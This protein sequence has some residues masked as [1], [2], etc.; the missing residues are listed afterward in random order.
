MMMT[1]HFPGSRLLALI[2]I[3]GAVGCAKNPDAQFAWRDSTNDLLP[4]A[5]RA[6]QKSMQENFGTP[7]ALVAWERMPVQYGGVKGTV[8]SAAQS[9]P[10]D[11]ADISAEWSAAEA[12]ED[13]APAVTPSLKVGDEVLWISG[14]GATGKSP[15]SKISKVVES[16]Q[17]VLATS[18]LPA[19]GD[20]FFVN[21]GH[22][23]QLGR[24]VYMKNCV[25]CH[26]VAGDGAGPTAHYLNPRPRDYRLGV[27]KFT[28]TLATER[29]THH[30]LWRVIKYGI[31]GTYMP[32]FLLLDDAET[33]AVVQYVRWLAMR[34]EMEKRLGD[35]LADYSQDGLREEYR[36]AKASYDAAI[37][38]GEKPDSVPNLNAM[39][40]KARQELQG[41]LKDDF[42]DTVDG[43]ADF[44]AE[45]WQRAEDPA[46]V[47]HPSVS[48]VP[49]TPASRAN[50]RLL[51]LSDK[52]KCYTCHGT[53]GRG[54]GGAVEDFW[55][56]P[57]STEK[58]SE[59]GLHDVWGHVLP[60]RNLRLGQYRGGR[61][62]VDVFRR[63]YAGIK[64]T[65]MPAF[66]GTVLKDE[67]IWDV[68]NYVMSL[69][70]DAEEPATAPQPSQ[71]AA[72]AVQ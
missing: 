33:D 39:F 35:E 68:V 58:Y 10:G 55:P 13:E 61:R 4:E 7:N 8:T 63:I 16:G 24:V 38:G 49:D 59:R 21:F 40:A 31:P 70:Y 32:S 28:E 45:A 1:S 43:T 48:R 51:Y 41:Y 56:K 19:E 37:A 69:P 72:R 50:G 36:K 27:F 15:K 6:V 12:S 29:A 54:N 71:V 60:P 62:P 30:D 42:A 66:G 47:I 46:S 53:T 11:L 5:R 44:I 14:A 52:T 17:F 25:H 2:L 57:G 22:E 20:Q 18:N 26:G 64:G 67:E 3:A 34:G 23:L 65:P 9:K